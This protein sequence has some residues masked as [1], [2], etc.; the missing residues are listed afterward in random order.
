MKKALFFLVGVGLLADT[1]EL[2]T[3]E[4][5]DGTF[6][7][8]TASGVVIEVAGQSLTIPLEKV[9]A[10]YFGKAPVAIAPSATVI[11]DAI[12]A[13]H[14]L[15]SVTESGINYFEYSRRVL[16]AKVKVDSLIG[17]SSPGAKAALSAMQYYQLASTAWYGVTTPMT[18]NSYPLLLQAGLALQELIPDCP[19]LSKLVDSYGEKAE[20]DQ[21]AAKLI[22]IVGS[23][24]AV[25]WPCAS[26][27]LTEAEAFSK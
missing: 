13:L 15:K 20:G 25:L 18:A 21:R 19:G 26:A 10:I 3:G 5:T 17:D 1:I 14:A 11:K 27:K 4:R 22:A 6:K 12:G 23:K 24:P 8:A 2:K 16:E 9:S 7:Q